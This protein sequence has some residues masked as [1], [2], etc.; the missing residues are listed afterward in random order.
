MFGY[1]HSDGEIIFA[2]PVFYGVTASSD[3]FINYSSVSEN[4][5][6]K[7]RFGEIISSIP[8]TGYPLILNERL[9]IFDND[10]C[11][12]SEW[13]IDGSRLWGKRFSTFITSF[14][15]NQNESVIGLMNGELIMCDRSGKILF[16]EQPTGSR[17]K[18]IY[19]CSIDTSGMFFGVVLGIDPQRLII[20][21]RKEVGFIP[22]YSSSLSGSI[23]RE[24]FIEFSEDG[25]FLFF[26]QEDN[27][28]RLDIKR[29]KQTKFPIDGLPISVKHS[30]AFSALIIHSTMK[31]GEAVDIF[32]EGGMHISHLPVMPDSTVTFQDDSLYILFED[33][34]Y[35]IDISG[36]QN[37]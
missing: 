14:D 32:S 29:K 33:E 36:V 26:E 12:V 35:R 21:Q 15:C 27:L 37:E 9:L 13:G 7:N 18:I 30:D 20:Y 6:I 19:G 22:V 8:S 23:R 31:N 4:L 24:Q 34:I 10:K 25:R 11:G 5:L 17:I 16:R 1:V 28:V 3:Y 2:E